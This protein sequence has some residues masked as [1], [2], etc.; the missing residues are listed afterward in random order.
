MADLSPEELAGLRSA[1][2]ADRLKP[3]L[4]VS[5]RVATVT[6]LR[7]LLDELAI[8]F[9]WQLESSPPPQ[10]I[11][12]AIVA[13]LGGVIPINGY[14]L[15]D[16]AAMPPGAPTLAGDPVA[17]L[18]ALRQWSETVQV[19]PPPRGDDSAVWVLVSHLEP[20]MVPSVKDRLRHVEKY[21]N[22]IRTRRPPTKSGTPNPRRLEV[23]LGDWIKHCRKTNL[24]TFDA[25]DGLGGRP[26]VPDAIAEDYVAGAERLYREV[27]RG[28]RPRE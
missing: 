16:W 14:P 11:A 26:I 12:A 10:A 1:I 27:F 17:V 18:A 3:R 22:E 28:K 6:Q 2:A 7:L 20:P 13:H 19:E 25:L 23:H 4:D 8:R 24:A 5:R 21:K 15:V 9:R